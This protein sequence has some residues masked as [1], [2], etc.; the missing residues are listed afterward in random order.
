M[1]FSKTSEKSTLVPRKYEIIRTL[2]VEF[3]K[4]WSIKEIKIIIKQKY[5]HSVRNLIIQRTMEIYKIK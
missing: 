2:D 1:R 5:V 3:E 4:L